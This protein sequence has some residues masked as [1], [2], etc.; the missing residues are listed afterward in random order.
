MNLQFINLT[1]YSRGTQNY[2]KYFL[3]NAVHTRKLAKY[4]IFTFLES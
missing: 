3:L 1:H 2:Q 4:Q